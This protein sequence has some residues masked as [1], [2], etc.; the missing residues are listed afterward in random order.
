MWVKALPLGNNEDSWILHSPN[1][2]LARQCINFEQ[3]EYRRGLLNFDKVMKE[4]VFEVEKK[5]VS[6]YVEPRKNREQSR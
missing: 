6:A 1:V 4:G 2:M 3:E 5:S